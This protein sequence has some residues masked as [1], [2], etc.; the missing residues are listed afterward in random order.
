M[1]EARISKSP[2]HPESSLTRRRFLLRAGTGLA[3][4]L[5]PTVVVVRAWPREEQPAE[6]VARGAIA[7]PT[8]ASETRDAVVIAGDASGPVGP[9]LNQ[10][11]DTPDDQV[12]AFLALSAALV[13]GGGLDPARARQFLAIVA[14]DPEQQQTLANLL[15]LPA[16]ASLA[17]PLAASSSAEQTMSEEILSFWYTGIVGGQPVADRADFWF[18]LSAWQAVRYTPATSACKGFAAWAEAPRI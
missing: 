17:T 5:A 14:A 7:S 18:G 6:N 3:L 11:P 10:A 12:S 2:P 4:A 8:A 16:D 13:G 9:P 15:T 1:T